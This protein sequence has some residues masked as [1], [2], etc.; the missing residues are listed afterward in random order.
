MVGSGINCC[1]DTSWVRNVDG[2]TDVALSKLHGEIEAKSNDV[3]IRADF[4]I[5]SPVMEEHLKP[6]RQLLRTCE[7]IEMVVEIFGMYFLQQ[8][9]S[10]RELR[11]V[12]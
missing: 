12:G 6:H 8:G 7:F 3:K 9:S 10:L 1:L 2:K 5:L 4:N 11:S